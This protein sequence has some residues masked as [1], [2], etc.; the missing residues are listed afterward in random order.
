MRK[1]NPLYQ[2]YNGYHDNDLNEASSYND[3]PNDLKRAIRDF[4][5]FTD[6]RVVI[7]S[8][9]ADRERTIIR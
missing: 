6:G 3:L 1:A 4:E 7:I 8:V 9:G 2:N 5:K